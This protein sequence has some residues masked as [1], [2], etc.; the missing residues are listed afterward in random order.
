MLTGH[1]IRIN[2]YAD[3]R[4]CKYSSFSHIFLFKLFIGNIKSMFCRIYPVCNLPLRGI[5]RFSFQ[6]QVLIN[7]WINL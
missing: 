4:D 2:F 6:L 5:S 7:L 1:P 3:I